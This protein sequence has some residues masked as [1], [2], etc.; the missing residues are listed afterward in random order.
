MSYRNGRNERE[1][2]KGK[3]A[4]RSQSVN[5]GKRWRRER[6]MKKKMS[7]QEGVKSMYRERNMES[8]KT[9]H[10]ERG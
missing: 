7:A 9:G 2:G 8:G 6:R 5:E 4:V 10:G 1:I 3:G